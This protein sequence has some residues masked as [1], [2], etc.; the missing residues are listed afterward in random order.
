MTSRWPSRPAGHRVVLSTSACPPR[1]DSALRRS[2]PW[3]PLHRRAYAVAMEPNPAAPRTMS[4]IVASTLG[5][6][7]DDPWEVEDGAEREP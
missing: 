7:F 1:F 2:N 3:C 4:S 5:D 6:S